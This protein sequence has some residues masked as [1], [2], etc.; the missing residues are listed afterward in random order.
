MTYIEL[1][2]DKTRNAVRLFDAYKMVVLSVYV[3]CRLKNL[4]FFQH[5]NKCSALFSD[6]HALLIVSYEYKS[7]TGVMKMQDNQCC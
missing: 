4:P 6:M 1:I 2:S 7:I 3:D 5:Q